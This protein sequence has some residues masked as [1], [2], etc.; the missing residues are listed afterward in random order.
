[1]SLVGLV[2][3]WAWGDE[4]VGAGVE[5]ERCLMQAHL[6][7]EAGVAPQLER[8]ERESR[9]AGWI[10]ARVRVSRAFRQL[11]SMAMRREIKAKST[12][13]RRE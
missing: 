10:G 7:A 6:F 13:L 11:R 3:W 8:G 9:P 1:M 5:I 4:V 2:E 12:V